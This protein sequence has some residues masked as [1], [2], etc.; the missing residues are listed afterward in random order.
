MTRYIKIIN[1]SVSSEPFNN[2][3]VL[4]LYKKYLKKV[5]KYLKLGDEAFVLDPFARNQRLATITNDLNP[6]FSTSYNLE[7]NDFLELMLEEYG[8][9]SVDMILFDPPYNATL[10]KEH[11]DDIGAKLE[12]WQCQNPWGRAKSAARS[13]LKVGGY[14]MQLGYYSKGLNSKTEFKNGFKLI[15]GCL[16]SGSSLKN[17]IIVIVEQ[18][19]QDSLSKWGVNC[20]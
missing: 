2:P 4:E 5:T 16:L 10:L 15:D 7:A 8:P 9:N 19:E 6:E 20:E 18:K 17:D 11:Y 12:L 14:Y 13:L 1:T 3:H